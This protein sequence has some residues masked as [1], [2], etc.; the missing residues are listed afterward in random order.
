MSALQPIHL[1]R[2]AKQLPPCTR[3]LLVHRPCVASFPSSAVRGSQQ[4]RPFHASPALAYPYKDD[5]NRESL[6]PRSHEGS[7]ST[8]D[9]DVANRV[10]TSFSRDKTDPNGEVDSAKANG[11]RDKDARGNPLE[12]SGAN[13]SLSK[14]QGDDAAPARQGGPSVK[15]EKSSGKSSEKHGKPV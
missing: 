4:D 5:Q 14:P 12:L 11:A 1:L 13:Q 3:S 6:K 10:S 8:S 7:Q 9:N 15:K 2:G